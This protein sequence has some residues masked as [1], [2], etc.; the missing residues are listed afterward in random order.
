MPKSV[1]IL[2]VELRHWTQNKVC[3]DRHDYAGK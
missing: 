3:A 1:D 2:G